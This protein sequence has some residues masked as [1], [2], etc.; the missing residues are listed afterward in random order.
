MEDN[1]WQLQE[2]KNKLSLL[3]DRAQQSG[4]QEITRHGRKTAVLISFED[5]QK[6]QKPSGTLV[7]FFKSASLE[8]LDFDRNTDAS[9]DIEL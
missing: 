4:P 1:V 6:I 3:I 7:D 8:D 9:R 2:A 5:F